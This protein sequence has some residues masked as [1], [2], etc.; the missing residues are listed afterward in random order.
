MWRGRFRKAPGGYKA[1][2]YAAL[3]HLALIGLLVVSFRF[4][5]SP[6]LA[7]RAEQQIVQAQAVNDAEVKKEIER[8]KKEEQRRQQQEAERQRREE[9]RKAAEAAQQRKEEDSRRKAAEAE[10]KRKEDQAKKAV[11]AEK[12]KKDDEAKKVAEAER[13]KKD[14]E[15]KK[16]KD[17]EARKTEA[18]KK[19][20]DD[21]TRKTADDQKRKEQ[22]KL[23][24][25]KKK[26]DMER[27]RREAESALR[28]QLTR[29]ETE[30]SQ[31]QTVSQVNAEIAKYEALIKQKVERSWSRPPNVEKGKECTIRV[32]TVSSGEVVSAVVVRSS[33]NPAFDRSAEVAVQK[34]TPL[35]LPEDKK[36]FEENFREFEFKFRPEA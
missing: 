21:E 20:K 3:V 18:E 32:R 30:R 15:A 11:E 23:A 31:A 1:F 9:G 25:A 22:D 26:E 12:K 16:R 7:P 24:Q 19:R 36:L 33:G 29:E 14:D 6:S 13:K 4:Q 35:P 8:L 27:R 28:D 17:D 2:A 34:A 5:A 10:K